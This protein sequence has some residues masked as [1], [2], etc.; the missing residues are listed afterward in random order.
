[1]NSSTAFYKTLVRLALPIAL[2]NLIALAAVVVINRFRWIKN[3]T[4]G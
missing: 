2:Q 1:M 3:L 4:E